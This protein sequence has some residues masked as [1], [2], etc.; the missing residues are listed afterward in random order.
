V[1]KGLGVGVEPK[2]HV[3]FFWELGLGSDKKLERRRKIHSNQGLFLT[4]LGILSGFLGAG[5]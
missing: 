4:G 1:L 5:Y 3:Q 2:I